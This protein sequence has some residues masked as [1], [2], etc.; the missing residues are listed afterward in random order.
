MYYPE[1]EYVEIISLY[2][3]YFNSIAAVKPTIVEL[4]I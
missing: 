2:I 1:E 3:K 4:P